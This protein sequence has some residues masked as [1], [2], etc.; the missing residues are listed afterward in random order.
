MGHVEEKTKSIL[1]TTKNGV[2]HYCIS[3]FFF[4]SFYQDILLVPTCLFPLSYLKRKPKDNNAGRGEAH[5]KP[6]IHKNFHLKDAPLRHEFEMFVI[7]VDKKMADKTK[8][9]I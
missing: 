2:S 6:T 9:C 3:L 7:I 1:Y 8:I 5:H 4:L